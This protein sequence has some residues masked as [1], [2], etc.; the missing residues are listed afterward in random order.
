M[1]L[2]RAGQLVTPPLNCGVSR[3]NMADTPFLSETHALSKRCAVFED[4][5]VVAYLY[6]SQPGSQTIVADAW[7][8]NRVDAPDPAD[9]NSYR[10]DPPPAAQGFAGERAQVSQPFARRWSFCWSADGHSVAI[11][12]DGTP[13]AFIRAA[14]RPGFSRN[15][16]QTGPWGEPWS[17]EIYAATFGDG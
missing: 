1:R 10:P 3:R 7:V 4:D 15:L 12:A 2:L 13:L 6:L 8:Y 16:N 14:R 11:C 5:G 17:E 9:V